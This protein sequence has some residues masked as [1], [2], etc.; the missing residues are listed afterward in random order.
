MYIYIYIYVYLAG[1]KCMLPG[2]RR[3]GARR[4]GESSARSKLSTV[5]SNAQRGNGLGVKGS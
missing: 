5:I 1:A 2:P 3:G 4:G